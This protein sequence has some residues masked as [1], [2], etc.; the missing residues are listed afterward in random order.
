MQQIKSVKGMH[1]LLPTDAKHY[2]ALELVMIELA[3]KFGYG[4]LRTPLVEHKN[5]FIRSVGSESDIVHKE[6]YS[7]NDQNGDELALRPEGTAACVRAGIEHGLFYG[8]KQRLWYL[9]NMFRR[10]RPQKGRYRQFSQF[11]LEAIGFADQYIEVE[12][13][14]LVCSLFKALE[15]NSRLEINHLGSNESRIKYVSELKKY[16]T[17]HIEHLDDDSKRRLNSNT[18]RIL[19]SKNPNTQA[20]L[21]SAPKISEFLSENEKAELNFIT[22]K[23][24]Q[25]GI[26]YQINPRLVRGLDYY[27][28]AV[29]EWIDQGLTLC[30]GGRY[31]SLVKQLGGNDT[32]AVGI[33]MGIERIVQACNKKLTERK[34]IAVLSN[35]DAAFIKAYNYAEILRTETDYS[36]YF[37]HNNKLKPLVKL[38]NQ[39]NCGYAIILGQ[40]ELAEDKICLKNMST[41]EQVLY[42][43]LAEIIDTL[44]NSNV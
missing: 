22:A 15:V 37:E 28:G 1:D 35:A 7:F 23:L 21:S 20:I 39:N 13:I 34:S 9:G 43:S 2:R 26:D 36:V 25:L 8:Q 29:F 40:H 18:L 17:L 3:E 5:L 16:L 24:S 14:N 11:G 30:A 12:I 31:D 41:G 44:E 27:T 6:M 32:P 38:A 33:A 10:E 19:D 4:E 42:N